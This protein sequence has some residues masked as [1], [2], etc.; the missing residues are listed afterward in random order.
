MKT[1]ITGASKGIGRAVALQLAS[2][3]AQLGLCASSESAELRDVVAQAQNK[4]AEAIML[5]GDL[6]QPETP[7]QIAQKMI[8]TY[9]GLDC[10]ISNAGISIPAPLAETNHEDWDKIFAVNTKSPLFLAQACYQALKQSQGNFI[11]ISSMSGEQP[12]PGMGPY[13]ASKSA[14]TMVMR[15]LAQEW[16]QDGI[17]VNIVSPGLFH[18]A[19]TDRVYSDPDLKAMREALVPAGR[20]GAPEQ[21]LVGIIEFLAQ[22]KSTY[23]IGQNII[24]DGGL[25]DSIQ[26]NIAGRP[27]T[28][29]S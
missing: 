14:L 19:M 29:R 21:D 11:A 12:Y 28:K 16:V 1:L 6:S 5:T 15:Q 22:N 13:S 8:E 27:A 10:V 3:G 9:N 23:L 20:I 7:G 25:I 2:P 26:N 4:G 17:K 18:T 24:V